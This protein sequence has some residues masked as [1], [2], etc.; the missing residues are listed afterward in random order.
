M[1]PSAP[2]VATSRGRSIVLFIL[3][4]GLLSSCVKS[5]PT[6][7]PQAAPPDTGPGLIDLKS[8]DSLPAILYQ[9]PPNG[10]IDG[11]FR[12]ATHG[13]VVGGH[14]GK[15]LAKGFIQ[16]TPVRVDECRRSYHRAG[17]ELMYLSPLVGL[18]TLVVIPPFATATAGIQG[19]FT[20]HS[21]AEVQE[22]EQ[23]LQKAHEQLT[24]QETFREHVSRSLASCCPGYIP[25]G[26]EPD[27]QAKNVQEASTI[28][29]TEVLEL[30]LAEAS[31]SAL[32]ESDENSRAIDPVMAQATKPLDAIFQ[33]SRSSLYLLVQTRLLRANDKSL[34]DQRQFGYLSTPRPYMEWSAKNGSLF[35]AEILAAY[36]SVAE[37]ISDKLVKLIQ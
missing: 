2:H 16:L 17:C 35:R 22:W 9:K 10:F 25:T 34:I 30:G 28:L 27:S 31:D 1:T 14:V 13:A 20:A 24:I 18:L 5:L 26:Q 32:P 21:R 36:R 11:F 3:F 8:V 19:G 15:E 4:F 12:G 6:L 29:E 7:P 37:Q 23:T 33:K